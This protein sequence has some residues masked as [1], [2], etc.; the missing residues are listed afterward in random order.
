MKKLLTDAHES[1]QEQLQTNQNKQQ[2]AY[3]DGITDNDRSKIL[4]E[5]Y[6]VTPVI[7]AVFNFSQIVE[8]KEKYVIV[9][10]PFLA[11]KG[12]YLMLMTIC[13]SG[14]ETGGEDTRVSV[15]LHL[16][17]GL[18]DDELEQAGRWPLRGV[19]KFE[20]LNQFNDDCHCANY[21]T[22]D[23]TVCSDCAERIVGDR[24]VNRGFDFD[25]F[26]PV[27][28]LNTTI[29]FCNDSIQFKISYS[30]YFVYTLQLWNLFQICFKY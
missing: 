13:P 15:Y 12:G 8:T 19:F 24:T 7:R 1:M 27:F 4:L 26:R 30:E 11:F 6:E 3:H 14:C 23:E 2:H 9:N 22:L 25:R 18:H 20:L 10:D 28:H 29:Y 16:M 5:E 21:Y 17:K